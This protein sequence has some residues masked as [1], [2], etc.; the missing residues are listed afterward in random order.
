MTTPAFTDRSAAD[1]YLVRRI[2]ARDGVA[3]ESLAALPAHELD[4]LLP[5]IRASYQHRDL[6]TVALLARAGIDPTSPE[7]QATAVQASDLLARVDQ[8]DSGHAA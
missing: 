1:Q 4:R 5:G 7:Y 3:P 8:L 6:F 2:A